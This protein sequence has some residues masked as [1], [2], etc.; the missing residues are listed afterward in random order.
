[1]SRYTAEDLSRLAGL[2][3]RTVRF[4]VSE[5]LIDPPQGRGRG[6][7]YD[8]RHLA[9]LKGVRQLQASGL[10]LSGI[11]AH[12]ADLRAMLATRG[13]KLEDME[14]AWAHQAEQ[15]EA[16]WAEGRK[17]DVERITR[18]SVGPGLELV[19]TDDYRMP[20]PAQLNDVIGAIARAFR[21]RA[22]AG[23]LTARGRAAPSQKQEEG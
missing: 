12:L 17:V 13:L 6:A 3:A 21:R 19:V 23:T 22:H 7:H 8:D 16:T 1:M 14:T 4:Y 10:D 11:R 5:K 2:T 18:I 20:P 15:V 9:Q